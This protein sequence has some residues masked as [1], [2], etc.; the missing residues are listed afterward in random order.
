MYHVSAT[1]DPTSR[2][3]RSVVPMLSALSRTP[4]FTVDIHLVPTS[5]PES[6]DQAS[7]LAASYGASFSDTIEFDEDETLQEMEATVELAGF[8]VGSTL[9]VVVE[10]DGEAV[11]QPRRI[12]IDGTKQSVVFEKSPRKKDSENQVSHHPRDEL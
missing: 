9:D 10:V 2:F 4:L 8:E 3:G 6:E 5:A 12:V 11:A 7:S 1:I